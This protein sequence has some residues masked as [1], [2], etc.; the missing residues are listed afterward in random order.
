MNQRIDL[1][2]ILALAVILLTGGLLRVGYLHEIARAPDFSAPLADAGFHD[3]W[4][5][6]LLDGHWTPPAGELDP[7]IRETPFQRPPGYPYF[8]AA[9]YALSKG[10]YFGVRVGQ[11]AL[12]LINVLLAFFLGRA[13]ASRGL[14]L[15]LAAFCATYWAFVYFEGELLAPVLVV[16]LNLATLLA[17]TAWARHPGIVRALVAGLCV[18][19]GALVQANMLLFAP[20]AALWIGLG[21]RR[22][23]HGKPVVSAVAF[24]AGAAL[25]IAPVTLRNWIVA[26][27]FVLVGSNGP[28]TLFIGNNDEADGVS[29]RLPYLPQLG[30]VGGWSWFSYDQMV[31]EI[32]QREGWPGNFYS[33]AERFF[34]ANALDFIR[35]KPRRFLELTGKRA[36]LFWGPDEIANNKAVQIEKDRSPVLRHLPGFP[37]VLSLSL[38]GAVSLLRK[39]R[40]SARPPGRRADAPASSLELDA[41][42]RFAFAACALFVLAYF[43]SFVPFLAASRFRTPVVPVL[44]VF[45]A[46]GLL[47]LGDLLQRKQ[48]EP[49]AFAVATWI[50]VFLACRHSF[51]HS[52]VDVA[53]FHTDRASALLRHG[54][55]QE[56]VR[57]LEEALSANPGYVDARV[58]L[59]QTLTQLGRLDEA[60]ANYKDVLAHR[61]DRSDLRLLLSQLLVSTHRTDEAIPELQELAKASPMSAPTQF[62]LG[63][64]LIESKREEEGIAALRLAAQLDPTQA[65][66]HVNLGIALDR[67]GDHAGALAE[68]AKALE[69]D[70]ASVDARW[71]RGQA[72]QA[73]G[74]PTDAEQDFLAAV[75]AQPRSVEPYVLLG[76][77]YLDQKRNDDAA[78]YYQQAIDVDPRSTVARANLAG[79]LANAGRYEDAVDALQNALKLDPTDRV[80]KERLSVLQQYLASRK[81]AP[82]PG[83]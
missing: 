57:E 50:V 10:S 51:Y 27:D 69:L 4:A 35:S 72:Y 26:K 36:M 53:W 22:L 2:A 79:A 5:R 64:A 9:L 56:A 38:V 6:A 68:F 47:Q 66:T 13:I 49:V 81:G 30:R 45:G 61:P 54:R 8:L 1:P 23:E 67:R 18:G 48:R 71:R 16:T 44:F 41:P 83:K 82:P 25:A 59:A 52:A 74:R 70:P 14:G 34:T 11:M 19:A 78:R 20:I 77:L 31:K 28:I 12:G 21:G 58:T 42:A 65:A 3:Y 75:R 24:L 39:Q 7:R 15:V 60:I 73:L 37:W 40:Q 46:W 33:R 55:T 62:E 80:C 17:L 63:R 43:L 76:N 32:A 29:S